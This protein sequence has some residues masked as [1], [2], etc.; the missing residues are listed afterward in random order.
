MAHLRQLLDAILSMALIGDSEQCHKARKWS[1]WMRFVLIVVFL[2]LAALVGLF[3]YGQMIEPDTTIIE[4][5]AV[6]GQ[7]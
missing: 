1:S 3:I 2:A 7:N 6:H 4:Q 5:E